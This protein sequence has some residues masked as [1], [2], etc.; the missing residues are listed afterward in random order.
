MSSSVWCSPPLWAHPALGLQADS[1]SLSAERH[2][3]RPSLPLTG[4]CLCWTRPVCQGHKFRTRLPFI[5]PSSSES[6]CISC[7]PSVRSLPHGR[8]TTFPTLRFLMLPI[9]TPCRPVCGHS[10]KQ[11]FSPSLSA[12]SLALC[13]C[14]TLC[15]FLFYLLLF[16]SVCASV[17][18]MLFLAV[19]DS[20]TLCPRCLCVCLLS[21]MILSFPC[22]VPY[23]LGCVTVS[24]LPPSPPHSPGPLLGW[25]CHLGSPEGVNC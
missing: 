6:R 15:I 14:L 18:P 1:T 19:C 8:E 10:N 3:G 12:S 2:P 5:F 20:H 22:P 4:S 9:W 21:P 11:S 7:R 16:L 24:L 23:L 17:S 25:H 13:A